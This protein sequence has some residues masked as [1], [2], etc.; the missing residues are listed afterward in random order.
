M[1]RIMLTAAAMVSLAVPIIAVP[2]LAAAPRCDG[3]PA[4]RV[5]TNGNDRIRGTNGPDV[6]VA[7]GGTDIINGRGGR[8]R[9]CGG[10][11]NDLINGG[12]GNDRIFGGSG[13]DVLNGGAGH[14][15]L[16]GFAGQDLIFGDGGNDFIDGGAAPD[17]CSQGAGAGP[18][19]NCEE[20][21]FGVDVTA[22]DD[23]GDETIFFLVEVINDGPDTVPYLLDIDIDS[24]SLDC[25][26]HPFDGRTQHAALSPTELDPF[27]LEISCSESGAPGG[28]VTVTA[29][30]IGSGS[31]PNPNNDEDADTWVPLI[32]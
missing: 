16:F 29:E 22:P 26:D 15:D 18:V 8:D 12:N 19:I 14:D 13:P 6:I 27:E 25:G 24:P 5:G 23:S 11:G 3:R 28:S 7:K 17:S 30:V 32:E 20:A 9:I 21:D 4:T 10:N 1:R 31:D 2:T